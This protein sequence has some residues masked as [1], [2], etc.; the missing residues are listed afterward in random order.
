[1]LIVDSHC[2]AGET[3]YEPV[4][5]L[6]D[7]MGTNGVGKA[8]LVQHGGAYDNSYLL[9]CAS[10]FPGRFAVVALVDT[11]KSDAP[12]ALERWA[13]QG[14]VGVRLGPS[15]RSPG[16][17]PLAI[18]RRA[19]ELGLVVSSLG[20]SEHFASEE[21][22]HLVAGLPELNVVIEHLAGV[23]HGVEPPYTAF[24]QALELAELPNTYIKVGGLGEITAR[25]PVHSRTTVFDDTSPLPEMAYEAF[26]ASRMMWGS[27]FPP[28][29]GRE[30]YRNALRGVM[31]HPAFH[32]QE[33]K[34]RIMGKTALEV[35]RFD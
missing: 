22:R 15:E 23:P 6:L 33:V 25:P 34:E 11:S 3:W 26:G 7:Q 12:S 9:E 30:G 1:M 35:F 32:S 27:D 4:E 18:W 14:A 17:D 28:V 19:A 10:R 24:R 5:V 2:H 21:F 20:E 13:A 8:V 31:D 16:P 29:S